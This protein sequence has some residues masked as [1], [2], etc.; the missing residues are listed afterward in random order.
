VSKEKYQEITF[1]YTVAVAHAVQKINPTLI[2]LFLSGEG[3][4]RTEKSKTI[5]A[6]VK[7]KAEN[8]LIKMDMKHL[9][10]ARPGGIK[11]IHKNPNAAFFYKIII[12][13]FP[14]LELL[15]PSK[16]INSVQ[17]AKAMLNIVKTKPQE[18]LWHNMDLK[19]LSEKL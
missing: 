1:D 10:I 14:L 15:F 12:P 7:G 5:F 11:P 19:N 13:F 6:R 4:D 2:F 8:A 18:Q 9:Y 3:A 17:L 16:M